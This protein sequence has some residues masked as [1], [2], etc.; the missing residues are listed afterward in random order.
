M[1]LWRQCLLAASICLVMGAITVAMS[2]VQTLYVS[3]NSSA[4]VYESAA[5]PQMSPALLS[6]LSV[7][8]H[9]ASPGLVQAYDLA[10]AAPTGTA[11]PVPILC[12]PVPAFANG[13]DG[14][15]DIHYGGLPLKFANGIQ[16]TFSTSGRCDVNTPSSNAH[17]EIR[18]APQ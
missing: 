10:T 8:N 7:K 12:Y 2:G 6:D 14:A 18:S 11:S 5:A 16:L 17:Y 9:F 4:T 3:G 1:R 15:F 13:V